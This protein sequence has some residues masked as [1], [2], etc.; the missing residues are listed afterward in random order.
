MN[1]NFTRPVEGFRHEALLY[2]GM[3]DFLAGTVPFVRGG[4]EAGEPILVVESAAK[5][6]LL[7]A[8]LGPDADS[9]LFADMAGV[10][11]NPARIIPAWRDFVAK[12]GGAGRR[13]RGIG[14]PIWNGRTPVELI[15]CQRHESLLNT[16]FETGDPWW[17]LCP[18]DT[19]AMDP[20]VID[21]AR[22]SHPYVTDG[23]TF[24]RSNDYRGLDACGAPFDV[25]LPEPA[26]TA[27]EVAFQADGLVGVR[28]LVGRYASAAGLTASRAANF[29]LAVNEVATNSVLHGGGKGTLRI[30]RDTGALTCEVRDAGH[31]DNPLIDRQ[32]P[33]PDASSP[34]GLWLANQLCDLVQIRTFPSGSAVRLHMWLKAAAHG[35]N[36]HD[37][38]TIES[39]TLA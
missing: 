17:L 16:A 20:A 38:H 1:S 19:E 28:G 13:L 26:P 7:K 31:I 29:V 21:E 25:P 11:A 18:Y 32:R 12:H 22:R 33:A 27:H 15:E 36:G 39:I 5:V 4:L 6:A 3:A 10:G 30:W 24:R 9:V 8:E 14:E 34:R 37:A 2:A 23:Q 35:A